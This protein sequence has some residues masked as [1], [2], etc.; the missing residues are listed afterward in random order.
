VVFNAGSAASNETICKCYG[1]TV[2]SL[3]LFQALCFRTFRS[4]HLQPAALFLW[5]KDPAAL[6]EYMGF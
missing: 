5:S 2:C 4:Y 1:K 3:Q 6:K